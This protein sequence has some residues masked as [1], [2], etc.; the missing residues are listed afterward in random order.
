[1]NEATTRDDVRKALLKYLDS[2]TIWWVFSLL[3]IHLYSPNPWWVS[4]HQD[5]P[6]PLVR[7]QDDHWNPLLT[8][9]RDTFDVELLTSDSVLF[10][11]QPAATKRKFDKVLQGFDP[12]QLAGG[13]L[14]LTVLSHDS[15]KVDSRTAME[16]VTYSTKSFIIA[17]ALVHGRITAEQ[18]ALASQVEVAS[19]IER[20]GEVED[21]TLVLLFRASAEAQFRH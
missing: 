1:M 10:S 8:W 4:F 16:R 14:L 20:W 2:D 19:Q 3:S 12:W 18:A 17:L 21:C 6:E 13:V 11:A 5:Y 15:L 7:L 9:V